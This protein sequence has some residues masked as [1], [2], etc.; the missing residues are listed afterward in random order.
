MRRAQSLEAPR[1]SL[2]GMEHDPIPLL[3]TEESDDQIQGCDNFESNA[4]KPDQCV[5]CFLPV[6]RHRHGLTASGHSPAGA[7]QLRSSLSHCQRADALRDIGQEEQR[8]VIRL[9]NIQSEFLSTEISYLEQINDLI[10]YYRVPMIEQNLIRPHSPD[11][12]AIFSNIRTI[13][14]VHRRIIYGI[15]EIQL[16]DGFQEGLIANQFLE[17]MPYLKL[18]HGYVMDFDHG[19][20]RARELLNDS[21]AN[22][23][24]EKYCSFPGKRASRLQMNSLRITPI[25]R[26][27]R[28]LLLFEE[29]A[30][31]AADDSP[32]KAKFLHIHQAMRAQTEKLDS[33]RQEQE[34]K[35]HLAAVN[36]Q[37]KGKNKLVASGDFTLHT[38]EHVHR[39]PAFCEVPGCARMILRRHFRCTNCSIDLHEECIPRLPRVCCG[40]ERGSL[41]DAARRFIQSDELFYYVD[42]HIGCK[43]EVIIFTDCVVVIAGYHSEEPELLA[44]IRWVSKTKNRYCQFGRQSEMIFTL[45]EPRDGIKHCFVFPDQA[46]CRAWEQKT[47][48]VFAAW[49]RRTQSLRSSGS[50]AVLRSEGQGKWPDDRRAQSSRWPA[51]REARFAAAAEARTRR[52]IQSTNLDDIVLNSSVDDKCSHFLASATQFSVAAATPVSRNGVID[53]VYSINIIEAYRNRTVLKRFDH[54][55]SLHRT[56]QLLNIYEQNSLPLLPLQRCDSEIP[57]QSTIQQQSRAMELYLRQLS[58]LDPPPL[59]IEVVKEF[60]SNSE[61]DT[62][63]YQDQSGLD[64]IPNAFAASSLVTMLTSH[65]SPRK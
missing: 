47:S 8:R 40:K 9:Q 14:A 17:A 59:E 60:F 27:A 54:V 48:E 43:A 11:D 56:L 32:D 62:E 31:Y 42:G 19:T 61:A 53:L 3:A 23:T 10:Q 1:I 52:G 26:I 49:T 20:V 38:F 15:Q 50:I 64:L 4:Y 6:T 39:P 13:E 5:H 34:T 55:A 21:S 35:R 36:K 65:V 51:D 12:Q 2:L 22:A 58:T 29:L 33:I 18:Y 57:D 25:Q 16:H 44:V 46:A 41:F 24:F 63:D 45:V 7:L 30:K 28:Y 37:L